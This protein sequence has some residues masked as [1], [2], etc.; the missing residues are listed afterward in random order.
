LTIEDL[1]ARFADREVV[2]RQRARIAIEEIGPPAVDALIVALENPLGRVRWEAAK[3]L[4]TIADPRSA[5]ALVRRLQDRNIGVRWLAAEA[6]VAVGRL[7]LRPLLEA[8]VS[9]A[10]SVELRDGAHHVLHDLLPRKDFLHIVP[11][12][13]ALEHPAPELEVPIAAQNVLDLMDAGRI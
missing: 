10:A 4:R 5:A 9:D 3:A 6:L 2:S 11:V 8:L 7:S 13:E 12:L 1:I